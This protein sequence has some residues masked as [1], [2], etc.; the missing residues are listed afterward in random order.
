MHTGKRQETDDIRTESNMV[1]GMQ[2]P[3]SEHSLK[4]F[5]LIILQKQILREDEGNLLSHEM[6]RQSGNSFVRKSQSSEPRGQAAPGLKE[7][8]SGQIKGNPTQEVT[9]E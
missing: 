5:D 7:K 1:M 6:Y 8:A 4:E 9:W 2:G 3:F